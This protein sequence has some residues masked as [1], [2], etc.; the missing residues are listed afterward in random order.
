MELRAGGLEGGEVV[1]VGGC[2]DVDA[3]FC[4][5]RKADELDEAKYGCV[6]EEDRVG[7]LDDDTRV[8]AV[9]FRGRGNAVVPFLLT[10]LSAVFMFVEVT[11]TLTW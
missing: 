6:G 1:N 7:T 9:R 2:E 11:K 4:G 3:G 5:G 10:V 8:V